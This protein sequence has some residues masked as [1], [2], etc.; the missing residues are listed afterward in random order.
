MTRNPNKTDR[1]FL[2]VGSGVSPI[3]VNRKCISKEMA[4]KTETNDGDKIKEKN[5]SETGSNIE[6]I[7]LTNSEKG[8]GKLN[9]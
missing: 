4:T 7:S 1:R 5:T 3:L 8:E 2:F 9:V 6:T